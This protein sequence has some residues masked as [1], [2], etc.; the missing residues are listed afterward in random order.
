MVALAAFIAL[1]VGGFATL[2]VALL[3]V[4]DRLASGRAQSPPSELHGVSYSEQ[5]LTG[6]PT[7]VVPTRINR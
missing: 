2:V 7:T 3:L 4:V 6:S 1:L 5:Q